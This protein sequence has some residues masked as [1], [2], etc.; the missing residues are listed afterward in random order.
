MLMIYLV[1][2]DMFD[3]V[4][5]LEILSANLRSLCLYIYIIRNG[6]RKG[7]GEGWRD[8]SRA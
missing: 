6:K 3:Y 5:E 1:P 8:R 4:S 2:F 7:E